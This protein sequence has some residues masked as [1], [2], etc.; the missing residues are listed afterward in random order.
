MFIFIAGTLLLSKAGPGPRPR[1]SDNKPKSV[2]A[3]LRH[4]IWGERRSCGPAVCCDVNR[5]GHQEMIGRCCDRRTR[6][7]ELRFL[8]F[9]WTEVKNLWTGSTKWGGNRWKTSADAVVMSSSPPPHALS[10][11]VHVCRLIYH[12]SPVKLNFSAAFWL[13]TDKPE[14]LKLQREGAKRRTGSGN[15]STWSAEDKPGPELLPAGDI[16]ERGLRPSAS[17][18]H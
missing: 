8:L 10:C 11:S 17:V 12:L 4:Q 5:C 16:R 7:F 9:C 3:E 18:P 14:G 6:T 13:L 15:S 2:R 1:D